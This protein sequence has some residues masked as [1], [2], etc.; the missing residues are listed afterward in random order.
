MDIKKEKQKV[1][2]HQYYLKNR[3]NRRNKI[4]CDLCN[5]QVC[6]EYLYK[7]KEKSICVRH[8]PKQNEESKGIEEHK[9]IELTE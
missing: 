3:E 7:H 4:K 6:A 2:N 8:R 5:R 1:Y 9:E